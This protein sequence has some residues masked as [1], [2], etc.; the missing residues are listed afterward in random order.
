MKLK[1]DIEMIIH[2]LNNTF[3]GPYLFLENGAVI[4]KSDIEH[5]IVLHA[6]DT[7]LWDKEVAIPKSTKKQY[8]K[9]KQEK[10][11]EEKYADLVAEE[12][13]NS[14]EVSADEQSVVLSNDDILH[15]IARSRKI[16]CPS[17]TVLGDSNWFICPVYKGMDGLYPLTYSK[18][19]DI[20]GYRLTIL[21]TPLMQIDPNVFNEENFKDWEL[22][23]MFIFNKLFTQNSQNKLGLSA[24]T[25]FVHK[26]IDRLTY[27]IKKA[28]DRLKI[29]QKSRIKLGNILVDEVLTYVGQETYMRNKE[30]IVNAIKRSKKDKNKANKYEIK[31]VKTIDLIV[32]SYNKINT[33][34]EQ[35]GKTVPIRREATFKNI[36]LKVV[37]EEEEEHKKLAQQYIDEFEPTQENPDPPTIEE[38]L[39]I[40]QTL[41]SSDY[42]SSF[43]T[44][45]NTSIYMVSVQ[46]EKDAA[47]MVERLVKQHYLWKYFE[48]IKGSGPLSAAAIIADIDFRSTVHPS[49]II[50]YLGL[51]NVIDK[52]N[53]N[54]DAKMSTDEAV[55]IMRYLFVD[56]LGIADRINNFDILGIPAFDEKDQYTWEHFYS[57]DAIK[58]ISQYKLVQTIY[59]YPLLST[60]NIDQIFNKYPAFRDLV[61]SIWRNMNIIDV[62]DKDGATRP[63]IKHRARNKKYDKVVCTYIDKNGKIAVKNSLGYNAELK[64]KILKVMFDSMQ[65]A[66]SP[67]YIDQVFKPYAARLERR[68]AAEGKDLTQCRNTIFMMARRFTI[69]RFLEDL[70]MYVRRENGW[71]TNGGTY[72]EAK[73][74]GIHRHGLNPAVYKD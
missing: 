37:E 5:F 47:N 49:A 48:G 18:L 2:L 31:E 25:V 69:Q 22:N 8:K 7:S 72:Y 59:R 30:N 14:E 70:W 45:I 26:K 61:E 60:M 16:N 34:A 1:E 32:D 51:D 20:K 38:A 44:Y 67:Y 65:K 9:K 46:S 3:V 66:S 50:R 28:I 24:Q 10:T 43:I 56:Y 36:L 23:S 62:I 17:T 58:T 57:T 64:S 29:T 4:K 39:E 13:M 15:L 11:E 21:S 12:D 74:Q 68:F 41:R 55:K 52:P 40:T 42:I 6:V 71:S 63:T 54:P 33:I 35:E 27:L 19:S 73:I 53:R